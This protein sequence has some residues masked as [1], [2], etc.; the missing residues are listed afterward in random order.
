[1]I[2]LNSLLI[3]AVVLLTGQMSTFVFIEIWNRMWGGEE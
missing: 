3:G 1:M 2:D